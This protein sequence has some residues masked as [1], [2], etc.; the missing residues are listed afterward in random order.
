[1]WLSS[2]PG[3]HMGS[4]HAV[5]PADRWPLS[6]PYGG[7]RAGSCLFSVFMSVIVDSEE[8]EGQL[9]AGVQHHLVQLTKV[10]LRSGHAAASEHQHGP[11]THMSSSDFIPLRQ[12]KEQSRDRDSFKSLQVFIST[13]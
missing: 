8:E 2:V 13:L 7:Q 10:L 5:F 4:Q 6:V 1:M 3:R 9:L 12:H 11:Y